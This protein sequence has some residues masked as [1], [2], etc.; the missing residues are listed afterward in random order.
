MAN[1]KITN[2]QGVS[3][4]EILVVVTI[5]A[6]LGIMT[7]QAVLLTIGGS[8]KSESLIKVRENLSNS[9][10]II[11][12]QIRNA[13]S[14]PEC[15]NPTDTRLDYLDQSGSSASFSCSNLGTDDGYVASGSAR[16]TSNLIKI[17]YCNFVCTP[18][19]SA[20]PP[21]VTVNLNAEDVGLGGSHGAK[22][23]TST[24]IFLRNY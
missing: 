5:F 3:L 24:Q 21:S 14:I 16:L 12:R 2:E 4:L 6:I 15:P 8:K 23:S 18:G 1:P 11:E 9:M 10:G 7:T 20:N 22:V 13:D 19:T 17:T